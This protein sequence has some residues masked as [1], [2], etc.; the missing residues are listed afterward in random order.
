M[1]YNKIEIKC[2]DCNRI[3]K[4]FDI[5]DALHN[6]WMILGYSINESLPF[7]RCPMCKKDSVKYP[8]FNKN[9]II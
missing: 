8:K 9:E 7:M 2:I 6:R 1:G 3:E 4:F 5:K